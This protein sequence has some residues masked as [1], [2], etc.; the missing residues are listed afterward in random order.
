MKLKNYTSGISVERSV[1]EIEQL[2]AEAGASH[3]GKTYENGE[4]FG[5]NFQFSV[6]GR[7]LIFKLPCRAEM[8]AKVLK[9]QYRRPRAGTFK[10]IEEQSRRTAWKL[11]LDWTS[12]QISMIK[13]EQAKAEEIF[14]PYL[15]NPNTGD[16][17]FHQLESTGFKLLTK[18]ETK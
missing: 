6:T 11:L 8:V 12:I 17:F 2:L 14:L 16:T 13:L 10:K 3:I 18:G 15:M 5:F 7:P 4:L 1:A 9:R